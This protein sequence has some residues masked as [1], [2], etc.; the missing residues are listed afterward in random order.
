MSFN[1]GP[2]VRLACGPNATG[3]ETLCAPSVR[4]AFSGYRRPAAVSAC[5]GWEEGRQP[6]LLCSYWYIANFDKRR[7]QMSFR[8]WVLDSGAFSAFNSGAKIELAAYTDFCAERLASDPKLSE[9]FA[10]DVIGDWRA[11]R[12]NVDEMWRRGVPAIPCYHA[13]EPWEVLLDYAK[14]FP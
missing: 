5:A 11:G 4:L 14:E 8:D 2:D 10:L 6:A 12:R 1:H 13:G 3:L 9:V 7:E